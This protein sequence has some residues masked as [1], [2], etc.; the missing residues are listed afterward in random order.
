MGRTAVPTPRSKSA[1]VALSDYLPGGSFSR[2]LA[3]TVLSAYFPIP[4]FGLAVSG[5]PLGGRVARS[6][7]LLVFKKPKMPKTRNITPMKSWGPAD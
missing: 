5:I 4:V 6:L 2:D 3:T 1:I 7:I